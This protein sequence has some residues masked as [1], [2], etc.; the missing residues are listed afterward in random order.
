MRETA[1]PELHARLEQV[2]PKTASRL[3]PNDRRRIVR[4][5]EV[6]ASTGRTLSELQTQF[7]GPDR[8]EATFAGIRRTRADLR[9]RIETRV[10]EMWREGLVEEVRGLT[11]GATA[12]QA[13]GYKE[14]L[15][16]VSGEYDE[17]EAR[18]LVIRNT[19]RLVRRQG[20]WFKRFPV[21]WVDAAPSTS[22]GDLVER[23]LAVYRGTATP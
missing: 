21:T 5:L 17:T 11:L 22:A 19:N 15:G 4:A 1:S 8:Y 18:R 2:D 20:T 10:D 3:H 23:I 16:F 6:H 12:R 14:V 7:H 13:V 9:S